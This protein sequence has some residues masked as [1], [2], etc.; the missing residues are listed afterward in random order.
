MVN[1][2]K[3]NLVFIYFFFFLINL[4]L[5]Y[6]NIKRFHL[7]ELELINVAPLIKFF[8]KTS[9]TSHLRS[10]LETKKGKK[11]YKFLKFLSKSCLKYIISIDSDCYKTSPLK[12]ITT[13]VYNGINPKNIVKKNIK[14][15]NITF[16]FIGNFIK[17]KGIYETLKVF[18]KINKL[19]KAKLI[20][21]GRTNN[22]SFLLKLFKYELDF[23]NFIKKNS[24]HNEKNIKILP[25]TF[26][27]KKF[28][29]S[30][31][32]ILF[33]GYMNAVGRPVIEA[34]FLKTFNNCIK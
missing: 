34:S 20:C 24:L 18:K 11:R 21:V 31:D 15:Q 1:V 17:R 32:I 19:Y 23:E 8:F 25:M 5:R 16:G 2:V 27:L 22:S 13:I 30:I 9:I 7:N 26:N 12:K 10:R 4:K 29:S 28:Y 6:K 3:R 33:P 14:R